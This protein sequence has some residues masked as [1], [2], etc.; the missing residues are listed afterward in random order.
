MS[1]QRYIVTGG[2][3]NVGGRLTRLL[4]D[5][6]H[7]VGAVARSRER[8]APLVKHGAEA[9]V[10]SLEDEG[11]VARALRGAEAVFTMVPP[12]SRAPSFRDYQLKIADNLVAA[13]ESAGVSRVV[14]LSSLGADLPEGLGPIS[15]LHHVEQRLKQLKSVA[16]VHLRPAFFMENHLMSVPLIHGQGVAGSPLRPE[17]EMP[18]IATRDIADRAAA[19]LTDPQLSGHSIIEL[20][21]PC[22]LSMKRATSA[23]GAAVGKPHLAY[24]QYP[25]D[26]AREAMLDA[27]ASANVVDQVEEM[28]RG[29]NSGRVRSLE[30]RTAANTTPTTIEDFARDVFAPAFWAAG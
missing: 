16:V 5:A 14:N 17:L 7:K 19:L 22:E 8:L 4:L 20:L 10:G 18:M 26:A 24:V 3:G 28:Y 30:G 25:H 2:S 1:V 15:G 21:G 6:G 12:N 11:F 23:L 27:G 13:I 29:F 9:L